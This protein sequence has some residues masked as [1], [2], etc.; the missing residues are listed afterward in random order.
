VSG[1]RADGRGHKAG[2]GNSKSG[3][4]GRVAVGWTPPRPRAAE[5][6]IEYKKTAQGSAQK[7]G[8]VRLES[9]TY[10]ADAGHAVLTLSWKIPVW[11]PRLAQTVRRQD[12]ASGE[13]AMLTPRTLLFLSSRG[14]RGK[15]EG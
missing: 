8:R 7:V 15:D 3:V 9:L 14:G 1:E 4:G 13:S 5:I 12:V 10:D 6:T 2:E 11:L